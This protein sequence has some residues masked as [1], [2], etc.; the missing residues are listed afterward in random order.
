MLFRSQ[1]LTLLC[2]IIKMP[3]IVL[4]RDEET[5]QLLITVLNSCLLVLTMKL[6]KFKT[7]WR[8]TQWRLRRVGLNIRG[9]VCGDRTTVF[10]GSGR[11]KLVTGQNSWTGDDKF[12]KMSHKTSFLR[13][14]R[15]RHSF[16]GHVSPITWW[17]SCS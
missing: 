16:S 11:R 1:I 15:R 17:V 4:F 12:A 5:L 8:V 3:F 10:G 9:I 6:I 13:W 7:S 2:S 14:A